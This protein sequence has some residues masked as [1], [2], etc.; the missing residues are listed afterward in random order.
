MPLLPTDDAM[1]YWMLHAGWE[2]SHRKV[3]MCIN[4]LHYEESR[5]GPECPKV[6]Y[7]KWLDSDELADWVQPTMPKDFNFSDEQIEFRNK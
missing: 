7:E 1:Y 2:Y 5:L 3:Q 4:N 6:D